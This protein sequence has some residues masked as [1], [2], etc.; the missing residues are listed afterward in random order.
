MSGFACTPIDRFQYVVSIIDEC[1]A[2][3][4][5]CLSSN[6]AAMVEHSLH[7]WHRRLDAAS[8]ISPRS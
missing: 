5:N 2:L 4:P 7:K 6:A 8:T 3:A 1:L